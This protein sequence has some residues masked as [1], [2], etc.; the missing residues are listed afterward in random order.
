MKVHKITG[1]NMR[2][3]LERAQEVHGAA[4]LVLSQSAATDGIALAVTSATQGPGE[5]SCSSQGDESERWGDA[6]E[7]WAWKPVKE[8][9]LGGPSSRRV[10]RGGSPDRPQLL[11]C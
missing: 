6:S 9:A 10:F 7:I 8:L 4:A 3:A 2:E 11:G 1:K 5:A